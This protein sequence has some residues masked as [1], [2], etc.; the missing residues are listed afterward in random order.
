LWPNGQGNQAILPVWQPSPAPHR[1][2]IAAQITAKTQQSPYF[3]GFH[4]WLVFTY[5]ISQIM[6]CM[7]RR[8][9]L[10]LGMAVMSSNALGGG[11]LT[12]VNYSP[13][14]LGGFVDL[15]EN[16]SNT[17]YTPPSSTNASA[18]IYF[19]NPG[20]GLKYSGVGVVLSQRTNVP[21]QL[22]Y[23]GT[24]PN[25]TSNSLYLTQFSEYPSNI[26]I[27]AKV[28]SGN[29]SNAVDVRA[30]LPQGG[31]GNYWPLPNITGA[32][33]GRV[34]GTATVYF[35]QITAA[36]ITG[37]S[38]TPGGPLT[39]NSRLQLGTYNTLY[40]ITNSLAEGWSA[41]I[42]VNH[43]YAEPAAGTVD[44]GWTNIALVSFTAPVNTDKAF[45]RIA[46]NPFNYP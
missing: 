15:A 10:A 21:L 27:T 29:F 1:E 20:T 7:W 46:S 14:I 44:N 32:V 33:D 37:I 12:V 42:A 5:L 11:L 19:R 22:V 40:C 25:G 30:L 41:A 4:G 18:E 45:Y 6:N 8:L 38:V 24:I 35:T 39:V 23:H 16:G 13:S 43:Y 3:I 34:Y 17:P 2:R 31:G 36:Q 28:V 26:L 9:L